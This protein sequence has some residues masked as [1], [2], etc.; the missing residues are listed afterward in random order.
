MDLYHVDR[1]ILNYSSGEISRE[2]YQLH[3]HRSQVL[4]NW[5]DIL[6][7]RQLIDYLHLRYRID[8]IGI[9]LGC[10]GNGGEDWRGGLDLEDYLW[11]V[12]MRFGISRREGGRGSI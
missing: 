10:K 5:V 12:R 1:F 9:H 8:P 6:L 11:L 2:T 4:I 3:L 7:T